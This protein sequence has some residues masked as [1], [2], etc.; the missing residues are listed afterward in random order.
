[1]IKTYT[2]LGI[3]QWFPKDLKELNEDGCQALA[4]LLNPI[5]MEQAWPIQALTNVILLR[6]WQVGVKSVSCSTTVLNH[7]ELK[8]L[9]KSYAEITNM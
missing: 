9:S 2:A 1:M 6:L 5:E 3:D 7:D 8:Y 4:D